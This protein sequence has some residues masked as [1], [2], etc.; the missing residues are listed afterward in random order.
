MSQDHYLWKTSLLPIDTGQTIHPPRKWEQCRSDVWVC[1]CQVTSEERTLLRWRP[2]LETW[3]TKKSPPTLTETSECWEPN[4]KK[5]PGKGGCWTVTDPDL[6]KR[7][8]RCGT[9][10]WWRHGKA[11]TSQPNVKMYGRTCSTTQGESPCESQK[12][13][14]VLGKSGEVR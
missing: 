7:P 9:W 10:V 1:H 11:T 2:N 5:R 3:L 12:R 4:V 6:L 14:A 13:T 8:G